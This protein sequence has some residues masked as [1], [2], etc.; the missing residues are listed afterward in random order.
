MKRS[1]FFS[2]L[3]AF[4]ATFFTG[5]S[6][7]FAAS[8]LALDLPAEVTV[9]TRHVSAADLVSST[10]TAGPLLNRLRAIDVAE[11]PED[12]TELT[13]RK[14]LL[15]IRLMLAGLDAGNLQVTGPEVIHVKLVE[16]VPLADTDVEAAAVKTLAWSL[17]VNVEDL[18]VGLNRPFMQTVPPSVRAVPG[19]RVEVSAPLRPQPGQLSL[20]VRLWDGNNLVYSRSGRFDVL[21]RHRV[22]VSRVSLS[23]NAIVRPED[24]QVEY[25]YLSKRA[26]E[27]SEND[28]YGQRV[29][30]GLNAGDV[31]SLRDLS[32]PVPQ[33]SEIVV[34]SRDKVRVTAVSGALQIHLRNAQAMQSGRVGDVISVRNPDSRETFAGTVTGPGTVQIRLR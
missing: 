32:R 26:D 23:R 7:T 27:P 34:K 2:L 20:A 13:L 8:P 19:L 24:V 16:P 11:I 33:I 14:S 30:T 28:V 31:L 5:A 17:G 15:R 6:A 29:R 1:C 10:D 12:A 3:S 25:R 4:M 18:Q 22:M 9:G 21:K